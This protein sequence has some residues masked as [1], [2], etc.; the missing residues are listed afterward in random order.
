MTIEFR[1]ARRKAETVLLG[2]V[3]PSGAGKTFSALLV[4]SGLCA[5][6]ARI[7]VID[8]EGFQGRALQYAPPG[9]DT[10]DFDHYKLTGPYSAKRYQE[11][12]EAAE[13]QAGKGGV[14][15]I[16]S[17]SAEH[18]NE[19]GALEQHHQL[20][21][22][23][24]RK[25]MVAWAQI[26]PHQHA[27]C[28]AILNAS[29]H[30]ILCF[31]AED[32][33]KIVGGK[34]VPIGWQAIGWK[35]WPYELQVSLLLSHD[36]KGVP[37]IDGFEWGKLPINMKDMVPTDLPLTAEVG[38]RLAA[39]AAGGQQASEA[40]AAVERGKGVTA[41]SICDAFGECQTQDAFWETLNMHAGAL[42]ALQDRGGTS[43]E[44]VNNHVSSARKRLGLEP[45][46]GFA[47][48]SAA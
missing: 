40:S 12:F 29:C 8:T 24:D 7:V 6:G 30:V 41:R 9:R 14:V 45:R 33:I 22:G 36:R 26:R 48:E 27:L 46:E 38:K 32:K 19:G 10:F 11:A 5:D 25:K 47:E 23:D 39:W 16:D 1:P 15:I 28:R 44:T 4:A 13:K 43:W 42:K 34:P 2:L 37:I 18:E 35:R 31:R 3:G 17:M 20:T 21:G